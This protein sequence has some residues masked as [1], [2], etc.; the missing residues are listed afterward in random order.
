MRRTLVE[1]FLALGIPVQSWIRALV[2]V[3]QC[4]ED[5]ACFRRVSQPALRPFLGG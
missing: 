5:L 3:C 4:A 2:C 1:F